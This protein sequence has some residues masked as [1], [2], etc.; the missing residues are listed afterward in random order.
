[1]LF[2][3]LILSILLFSSA[4]CFAATYS[5][6]EDVAGELKYYTIGD[7]D[8][9]YALSRR[10]DVGIVEIISANQGV[11]PWLPEKGSFLTVPALY[12]LPKA[13]HKGIVVNLPELRLYYYPDK[14]KVMTFPIGIGREGWQTPLGPNK[15]VMKR[16]N[17][18]WTPPAS[19]RAE[20]PDLPDV[21]PA[22]PDNPMGA[23]ALSLAEDGI[24][25][26]G[27]NKPY[28][29]GTRSSHGCIRMYPEDIEALFNAVQV[30]TKVTIVDMPYKLGWWDGTL[31]LEVSPTQE[32]IDLIAD[33]YQVPEPT[34]KMEIY[35]DVE[36][37]VGKAEGI[38]WHEVENAMIKREGIPI[39]IF[40]KKNKNPDQKPTTEEK[41]I[42]DNSVDDESQGSNPE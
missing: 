13:E 16:K 3:T 38:K 39:A 23:Y 34:M 9:L 4:P 31:F 14:E 6:T 8:D 40:S 27:T 11:D 32:E 24:A 29:I 35:R 41:P 20:N 25:I 36:K 19:I 22:G 18:S 33:K 26:H 17:P 37:A 42:E 15:I 2:R 12:I 5:V 7:E 30:G 1:M 21:V 10:F 28:G